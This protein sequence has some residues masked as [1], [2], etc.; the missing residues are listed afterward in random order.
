MSKKIIFILL[1]NIVIF[2][3]IEI[4][5]R[6]TL[7]ILNY[8]TVYKLGNIDDNRYDYLTG[9]YNIPNQSSTYVFNK[10]SLKK[11]F[12]Q[13]TDKYGFNLD[14]MRNSSKDL[15]LKDDEV[16][17]IFLVGGSTVQGRDLLDKYDPIS[18]RLE[19]KLNN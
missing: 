7:S 11:T 16:F 14:G 9:Y 6:T 5:I 15:T 2:L 3:F 17:R 19:K 12:R 18:A 13:A 8:P 10:E 1:I 4:A